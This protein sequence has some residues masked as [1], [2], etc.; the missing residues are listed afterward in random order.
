M[1]KTIW[2][3]WEKKRFD[4]MLEEIAHFISELADMFPAVKYRQAALHKTEVSAI[5]ETEDLAMWKTLVGDDD[6]V[7]TR[8]MDDEMQCRRCSVTDWQANGNAKMWAGDDNVFGVES[9]NHEYKRFTASD[10]ADIHLGNV[11][12]GK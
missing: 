8:T 7:L 9:K 1:K 6:Q 10:S 3:L 11:N 2:P 5:Q 4:T 12:Q